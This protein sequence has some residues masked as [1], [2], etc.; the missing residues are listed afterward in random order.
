MLRLTS[1]STRECLTHT[2]AYASLR[3][4]IGH[5]LTSAHLEIEIIRKG[6]RNCG[7]KLLVTARCEALPPEE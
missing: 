2:A 3:L 6:T 1:Q 7:L 5:A 4:D